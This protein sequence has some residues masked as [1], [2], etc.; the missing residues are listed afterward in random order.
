[1]RRIFLIAISIFIALEFFPCEPSSAAPK[2]TQ[3][4]NDGFH[5]AKKI[6][7]KYFTILLENGVD[8]AELAMKIYV[9]PSIKAIIKKA[10]VSPYGYGL[11]DQFDLL[12][13]AISE[14]MDIR[15]K[16]FK[17]KVKVCKNASSLSGITNKLFGRNIRTPG[18]YVVEINTLY[19]DAD[20]ININVLGHELSHA[21]QCHYFVVPP[22]TKIQEVLAGFV[23]FQ[24][25]KYTQSLP[26]RG[27]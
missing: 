5:P 9:P 10:P 22:P 17:C 26:K 15:L 11:A 21:V 14:I 3:S 19:V 6:E 20:N 24:L 2:T 13:L 16:K 27:R 8:T 4:V 18:F 1:M 23:E 7:S 25:R 12:F